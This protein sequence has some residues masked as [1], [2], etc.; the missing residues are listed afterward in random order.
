MIE[1]DLKEA[2]LSQYANSPILCG[3]I[4]RFNEAVDPRAL[5]ENFF[6]N[7]WNPET[8][9][10]WGLDA[11]GRIVGVG[12][13]LKVPADAWFGFNQADDG[14]Q[15]ITPFN[16]RQ[17]YLG[18]VQPGDALIS[19]NYILTDNAYRKLIFAKAASNITSGSIQNI[20]ALLMRLFGSEEGAIWIEETAPL[21][22]TI[23]YNFKPSPVDAVI[24]EN[25]GIL[26]RA[27]G[28]SVSYQHRNKSA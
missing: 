21:T 28:V 12:R 14:S 11:W 1:N 23:C 4:T 27:C 6:N 22:I 25:S 18:S 2:L 9:T 19:N 26:P 5:I 13:V 15:T 24:I 17:F 16:D 3:I 7:V 8:A 10:S 20:N